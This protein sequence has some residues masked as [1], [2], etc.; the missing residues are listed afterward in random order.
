MKV[1]GENIYFLS[2]SRID[3]E[4]INFKE[5]EFYRSKSE[6]R[7]KAYFM[8]KNINQDV[9]VFMLK[10]V[11]VAKWDHVEGFKIIIRPNIKIEDE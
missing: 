4:K 2:P 5:I 3:L 8:T 1:Y 11:E 6:A 9:G 10:K 7:Q